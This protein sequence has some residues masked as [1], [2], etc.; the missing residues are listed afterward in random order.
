MTAQPPPNRAS[1]DVLP[2]GGLVRHGWQAARHRPER[3]P[4]GDP[5]GAPQT[6]GRL[7]APLPDGGGAWRHLKAVCAVAGVT[8]RGVH[9][10]RH[11]AGTRVYAETHDLEATARRLGHS[12]LET[13]RIYATWS[14]RQLRETIDR[15]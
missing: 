7:G 8:F 1:V 11:S 4:G 3:H 9:A 6:P 15:W 10:L 12:K 14:D 5:G 2:P 13:T